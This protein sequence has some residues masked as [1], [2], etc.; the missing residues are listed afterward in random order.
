MRSPLLFLPF[1]LVACATPDSEAPSSEPAPEIPLS[2]VVDSLVTAEPEIN[3]RIAVA[4]PQIAGPETVAIRRINTAVRDSIKA[5]TSG[6]RPDPDDFTGDPDADRIFVG[7]AEGGPVVT[8]LSG[9]VFSSRVDL[10]AFTGGAHGNTFSFPFTYDLATGEPV[11]L[12]DL[13]HGG[14][15]WLD[16]LAMHVTHH[17]VA[18][19][20][21]GWMFEDAIPPD[22]SY[23]TFFTLGADSL[24]VFFPPYAIAS[25]ADGSS[26]VVLPYSALE[27]VLDERGPVSWLRGKTAAVRT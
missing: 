4:Y 10:Y 19:R 15:A 23:F 14:T 16:T 8:F 7:E 18:E 6:L 22:P 26:E 5:F 3:Y 2:V 27:S 21:T 20:G 13:F 11:R 12:G 17:L 25:Y 9:R 1:V 24:R